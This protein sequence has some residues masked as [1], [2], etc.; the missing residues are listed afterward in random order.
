MSYCVSCLAEYN[1]TEAFYSIFNTYS[2]DGDELTYSEIYKT[3][4]NIVFNIEDGDKV[5]CDKCLVKLKCANEFK[6][7]TFN[8]QQI[9]SK[10]EVIKHEKIDSE[11][12]IVE[13][14]DSTIW[15]EEL[16]V[17]IQAMTKEESVELTPELVTDDSDPDFNIGDTQIEQ[18][19]SE[20]DHCNLLS[21]NNEIVIRKVKTAKAGPGHEEQNLSPAY[22]RKLTKRGLVMKNTFVSKPYKL[23]E[24][25]TTCHICDQGFTF[26]KLLVEHMSVHFPNCVCFKCGKKFVNK[27]SLKRHE[28]T[29]W[30]GP[31]VCNFCDKTFNSYNTYSAHKFYKHREEP[32]KCRYCSD[33]FKTFAKRLNHMI[34]EH[35]MES[36]YCCNYCDKKFYH[37]GQRTAHMKKVHKGN[38]M[39]KCSTCPKIFD[40]KDELREHRSKEHNVTANQTYSCGVCNRSLRSMSAL[41]YHMRSHGSGPR[42]LCHVCNTSF[43]YKCSLTN[44]VR[45]H[46][47]NGI[48]AKVIGDSAIVD[49]RNMFED[50]FATCHDWA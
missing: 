15:D 17:K 25:Q 38:A 46:K 32:Y 40:T 41:N 31:F 37:S 3:C 8:I 21:N 9:L 29:H 34:G 16:W 18:S 1:N 47:N 19:V 42:Y 27:E 45:T 22:K 14:L 23:S 5:V 26:Q 24:G 35:N 12:E 20:E 43:I 39:V 30:V 28:K 44:H 36:K 7:Q 6:Q 10:T 13:Y 48:N 2:N 4:F 11:E 50:D 33:R 49:D